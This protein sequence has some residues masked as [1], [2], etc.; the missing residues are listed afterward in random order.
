M[1][2]S[3]I[4]A[5]SGLR[6]LVATQPYRR[7]RGGHLLWIAGLPTPDSW[8]SRRQATYPQ[9]LHYH[10]GRDPSRALECR[11]RIGGEGSASLRSPHPKR[12]YLTQ[13][14]PN[15]PEEQT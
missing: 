7:S 15:E 14:H 9:L 13:K 11:K 2:S 6:F 3:V 1:L 8:R 12:A 4:V 5:V 10:P